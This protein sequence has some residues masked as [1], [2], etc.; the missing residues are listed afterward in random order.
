M[1][2]KKQLRPI[3]SIIHLNAK[4]SKPPI[5]FINHECKNIIV[6]QIQ[7]QNS[8]IDEIVQSSSIFESS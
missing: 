8:L 3:S 5:D 1:S 6:P 7:Y 4:K 2:E